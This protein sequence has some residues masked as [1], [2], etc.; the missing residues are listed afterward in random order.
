MLIT[1]GILIAVYIIALIVVLAWPRRQHHPE[2]GMAVGCLMMSIAALAALAIVL[3]AAAHFH[4][5]WLVNVIFVATVLPAVALIPQLT[6]AAVK[7][8]RQQVIDRGVPIATDQLVDRLRGQ[9]HVMTYGSVDPPREWN[10]LH[11]FSPD[12]RIIRYREEGGR[13]ERI[14]DVVTWAIEAGRLMTL[15]DIK[16]GN[17]IAYVLHDTP[18]G[19][20]AYY[21][22]LPGSRANRV[23]S[24]RTSEIRAGEPVVTPPPL[25]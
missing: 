16:P 13:I 2:D 6:M 10:E 23:L 5:G 20:V 8:R 14:D 19:R 9:T 12:G 25:E 3:A 11:F 7:K 4:V 17:R 18:D 24:R 21:I 15:N 1:S 22:H